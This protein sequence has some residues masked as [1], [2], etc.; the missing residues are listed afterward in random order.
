[1]IILTLQLSAVPYYDLYL[2]HD[3]K[4]NGMNVNTVIMPETIRVCFDI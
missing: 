3:S 4:L 2:Q 1:M